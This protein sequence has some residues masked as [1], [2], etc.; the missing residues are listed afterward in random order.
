MTWVRVLLAGEL[1]PTKAARV[2]CD[3][4]AI[5]VAL[6]DGEP[7]A[8][9]D[10]CPHREVALSGGLVS[11]GRDH[12]PRPLPPLRPAHRPVPWPRLGAGRQL[13]LLD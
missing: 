7:R 3:G 13:P 9:D 6:A 4:R 5:C 2:S 10:R 1:S 8:L 11:D 12:L